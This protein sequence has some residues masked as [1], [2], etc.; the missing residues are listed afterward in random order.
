MWEAGLTV[1]PYIKYWAHLTCVPWKLLICISKGA[2][3]VFSNFPGGAQ[4]VLLGP[5]CVGGSLVLMIFTWFLSLCWWQFW[6]NKTHMQLIFKSLSIYINTR[7]WKWLLFRLWFLVLIQGQCL[8]LEEH[9]GKLSA[10]GCNAGGFSHM[11]KMLGVG[12]LPPLPFE[13]FLLLQSWGFVDG[14]NIPGKGV[15]TCTRDKEKPTMHR[16]VKI[17]FEA[18]KTYLFICIY[19]YFL[20]NGT[21]KTGADSK[22]TQLFLGILTTSCFHQN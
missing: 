11:W 19:I 22:S 1:G 8:P 16:Q 3:V 9:S 18:F 10:A 6:H 20:F 15:S 13:R 7:R 14:T 21:W 12:L 2:W 17:W 5:A 4:S